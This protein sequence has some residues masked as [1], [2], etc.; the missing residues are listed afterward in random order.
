MLKIILIL[1][2]ILH[3]L[4]FGIEINPGDAVTVTC[5]PCA[6]CPVCPTDPIACTYSYSTWGTCV[7]GLQT[8]SVVSA[9][10]AGC[11][12]TPVTQQSCSIPDP[13]TP[14]LQNMSNN[15]FSMV[16]GSA[17]TWK[18]W[19]SSSA[20]FQF[21]LANMYQIEPSNSDM[22]IKYGSIPTAAD[23]Q[24]A[25]MGQVIPDLYYQI[26][27]SSF[28]FVERYGIKSGWYY[29]M[30]QETIGNPSKLRLNVADMTCVFITTC[31]PAVEYFW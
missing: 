7:N 11:V 3:G 31:P 5:R 19:V 22:F 27:S 14:E 25:R 4:A 8:R 1:V 29:I 21:H 10:P 15:Y 20:G 17:R 9:T 26:S 23:M 18:F 2:L 12:G 6:P 24:A 30:I 28:E 16:A 13:T